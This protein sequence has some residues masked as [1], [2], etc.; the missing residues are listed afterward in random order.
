V[1][2]PLAKRAPD[3]VDVVGVVAEAGP[4]S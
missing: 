4:R 3:G 1:L 2:F